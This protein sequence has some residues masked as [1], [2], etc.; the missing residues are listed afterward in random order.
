MKKILFTMVITLCIVT[1]LYFNQDRTKVYI[2]LNEIKE[3]N[4][5]YTYSEHDNLI[6]IKSNDLDIEYDFDDFNRRIVKKINHKV[7]EKYVWLEN[8]KLLAILDKNSNIQQIY[9]YKNQNDSLPVAMEQNGKKYFFIYNKMKSLKVVVNQ[10]EDIEKVLTYNDKGEVVYDS[11]PSLKVAVG[12][13]GGLYDQ[14]SGLLYFKEGIYNPQS[15]KWLTRI[16]AHDIIK[17]LKELNSTKKNDVY[18]CSA[19]LD[20]YYHSYL[21]SEQQCGGLYANDYLNYFNGTGEIIDD[22]NYFNKKICKKIE[23]NYK[24]SDKTTFAQCVNKMI[25]PRMAK[26]FDVLI[27]NCHDEV[28][29]I[30]E[31]CSKKALPK[32]LQ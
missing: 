32:G 3:L 27:Y 7:I 1:L 21:C 11:N 15:A 10:N 18:K 19:T 22:S 5:Q 6:R 12:Y 23:P 20:V 24:K 9:D 28:K 14:D 25:Q 30:I 13:A 26:R 17:N 2:Q 31:A 8:N 16:D 4:T 29:N